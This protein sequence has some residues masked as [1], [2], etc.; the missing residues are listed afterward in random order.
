MCVKLIGIMLKE[1]TRKN[2]TNITIPIGISIVG[3]KETGKKKTKR[4]ERN[5]FT[6]IPSF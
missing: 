4:K 5:T 1:L 6:K 3:K 2:T